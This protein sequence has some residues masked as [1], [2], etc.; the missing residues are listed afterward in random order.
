MIEGSATDNAGH[1]NQ[2]GR[3]IEEQMRFDRA[4]DSVIAWIEAHGG[5]DENLLII[6]ADHETGLLASP[7]LNTDSITLNHYDIIDNGAGVMPGMEFY[8]TH[9]SNQLIPFFA[10]GAGSEIYYEYADEQDA[11]RGKF[12]TNSEIAQ[13]MFRLWNGRPCTI[14]NNRPVLIS[15]NPIP[16][17]WLSL[18]VDTTFT[19]EQNFIQDVEDTEFTYSIGA[20]PRWMTVDAETLTFSG[21][22]DKTGRSTVVINVTDGKTTGAGLTTQASFSVITVDNGTAIDPLQETLTHAYPNPTSTKLLVS[23]PSSAAQ[24]IMYN[25]N[26]HIVYNKFVQDNET[27]ILVSD[28]IPGTYILQI[29]EK[30]ITTQHTITIQ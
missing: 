29:H 5:W 14:L 6:T 17:I 9:H 27:E 25:Q 21:T 23:I 18:G 16:D 22:P 12:L 1:N 7:T 26:G 20:R 15:S 19:I 10:K 8:S 30:G 13:G 28:M 4:V 2:K 3:I 11:V 24:I